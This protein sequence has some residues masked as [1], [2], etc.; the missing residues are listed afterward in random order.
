[1]V[2][3]RAFSAGSTSAERGEDEVV[4]DEVLVH[5][6]GEHPDVRMLQQDVGQRLQLGAPCR[7]R[8]TGSTA[9]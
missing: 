6:V 5:V 8:P 4:V 7:R 1:M 3:V 2:S 9:S